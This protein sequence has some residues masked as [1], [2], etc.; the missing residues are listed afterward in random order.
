MNDTAPV[1]IEFEWSDEPGKW[2]VWAPVTVPADI[3]TARRVWKETR[4]KYRLQYDATFRVRK[5][6]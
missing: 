5:A 3:E 6:P 4:A 1:V 2:R